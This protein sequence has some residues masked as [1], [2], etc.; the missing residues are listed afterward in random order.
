VD[1]LCHK[2]P[3]RKR[4]NNSPASIAPHHN[5]VRGT[6]RST[7]SESQNVSEMM[8]S[9]MGNPIAEYL[10]SEPANCASTDELFNSIDLEK[11]ISRLLRIRLTAPPLGTSLAAPLLA[12]QA[13]LVY[14][15]RCI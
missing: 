4:Q 2:Q 13:S 12:Q 1:A 6:L 10:K 14:S 15:Y 9:F 7:I 3:F 8:K 5:A 11:D